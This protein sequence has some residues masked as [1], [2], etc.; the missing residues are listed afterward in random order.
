MKPLGPRIREK[1]WMHFPRIVPGL[2]RVPD[3]RLSTSP[4]LGLPDWHNTV[5]MGPFRLWYPSQISA[6]P[7]VMRCLCSHKCGKIDCLFD[8]RCDGSRS[9]GQ[10]FSV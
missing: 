2:G 8:A 10:A 7:V 4:T 6:L 1:G 3:T 9:S 5:R